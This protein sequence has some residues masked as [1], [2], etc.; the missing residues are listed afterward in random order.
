MSKKQVTSSQTKKL[1]SMAVPAIAVLFVITL[2]FKE[3]SGGQST[4]E[5][6]QIIF[7]Y[8]EGCPYCV[9][10]EKYIEQN[11][12]KEKISFEEK[13][14]YNNKDNA[15]DLTNKA[16]MCGLSTNSIG[17]PFLWNGSECFVGDKEITEFFEKKIG[18]EN[19]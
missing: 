19:Q 4:N 17:V 1:L 2:L 12:I 18:E 14:V 9:V 10:V 6:N 11:N 13:E 3:G 8:G 7:F 15:N 16:K 5:Q